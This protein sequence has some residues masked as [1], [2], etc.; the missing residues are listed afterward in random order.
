MDVLGWPKWINYAYGMKPIGAE[1]RFETNRPL[2]A[3][4]TW[5]LGTSWPYVRGSSAGKFAMHAEPGEWYYFRAD[6]Y[7]DAPT[8][9]QVDSINLNTN[10]YGDPEDGDSWL[11]H[12][13]GDPSNE[14]FELVAGHQRLECW[15]Q[16]IAASD[17]I[18]FYVNLVN[19]TGSTYT[20]TAVIHK[21]VVAWASADN[22]VPR[23]L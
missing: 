23:I 1:P 11:G 17:G 18:D 13:N 6:M 19:S 4:V 14:P 7:I 21:P 2:D 15:R 3:T 22:V 10:F 8:V 20:P 9:A 16:A 12:M 5:W